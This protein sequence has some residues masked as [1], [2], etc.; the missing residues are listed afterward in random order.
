MI[1]KVIVSLTL[2]STVLLAAGCGKANPGYTNTATPNYTQQNPYQLTNQAVSAQSTTAMDSSVTI[3]DA[4]PEPTATPAVTSTASPTSSASPAVE[5][6][7]APEFATGGYE[8]SANF[9]TDRDFLNQWQ[10]VGVAVKGNTLYVSA[11]DAKGF[12]TSLTKKGTVI[13][14]DSSS[15]NE[16]KDLGSSLLVLHPIKP[17]VTGIAV[18]KSNNIFSVDSA[19]YIYSLYAPKYSVKKAKAAAGAMDIVSEGSYLFVATGSG[20]KKYSSDLTGGSTFSDLN[21]TGGIGSDGLGNIY[22]VCGTVIKKIDANGN[23]VDAVAN[24]ESAIDVAADKNGNV[25]VLTDNGVN[26]YTN[27][28]LVAIFGVGTYTDPTSIAIDESNSVYVADKGTSDKDSKIVKY[29]V[30]G[31]STQSVDIIST[32]N[33]EDVNKQ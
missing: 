21:F 7:A 5:E 31:L 22:G 3:T 33:A 26:K 32:M 10:A 2:A 9:K 24:V 28:Q 6:S 16:W 20:L 18:D 19:E 25:F 30:N 15:G 27:G 8:V 11:V 23:S 1:K 14:M 29:E 17:T 4:S 13:K 12:L